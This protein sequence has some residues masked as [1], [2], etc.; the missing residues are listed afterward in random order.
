[1]NLNTKQSLDLGIKIAND[2]FDRIRYRYNPSIQLST[3]DTGFEPFNE[4]TEAA[5]KEVYLGKKRNGYLD[6]SGEISV[7]EKLGEYL[8]DQIKA[9]F[10][11]DATPISDLLIPGCGATQLYSYGVEKLL[12]PNGVLIVPV[13]TYGLFTVP[14]ELSA[15]SL[16][17]LNLSPS[18]DWKLNSEELKS[19]VCEN[20]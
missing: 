9:K 6:P 17:P 4:I 12:G 15:F 13:P 19:V 20:S 2:K 18:D 14:K 10:P 3:G 16:V 7:R 1:M 11:P 5:A 8:L